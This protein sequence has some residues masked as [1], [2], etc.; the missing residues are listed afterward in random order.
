M[1]ALYC[2]VVAASSPLLVALGRR[3][4]DLR[5]GRR[6]TRADLAV[7]SGISVRFLARIEAGEGNLS[8][9]RLESL[10]RAFG[11]TP[12]DLVR[13]PIATRRTVA[14]VG[15]RGA[16]KSTV[17]ALLARAL[18]VPFVEVDDR[19]REA[20]ALS[21]DE[22]FE[23]HGERY[24]RRLEHEVLRSILAEGR[25]VVLAAGG[26]VV[27]EPASWRMLL[28]RTTVVWLRAAAEE[29][30]GRVVAQ[31]DRRPMADNPGAMNDLRSLLLAREPLYSAAAVAVDTSRR[32]PEEIAAD[33]ARRLAGGSPAPARPG[34]EMR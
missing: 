14:L 15:L 30:W 18:G 2:T 17:G 23:M 28:E 13:E 9:R 12:A 24:Y 16:G 11:T 34:A 21:L 6:W 1:N 3:V 7:E 22:L 10:A 31:G 20:S 5:R 8:V 25:D 19:I 4:R 33:L 32:A 26:G 29:H 27:H